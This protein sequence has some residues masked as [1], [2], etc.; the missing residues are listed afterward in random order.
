LP[1]LGQL[2]KAPSDEGAVKLP[3]FGNLTEGENNKK[4]GENESFSLPQ[5][6]IGCEE[7][8][9]ASPLIRGGQWRLRRQALSHSPVNGN[10]QE[11]PEPGRPKGVPSF[12]ALPVPRCQRALPARQTGIGNSLSYSGQEKLF[13]IVPEDIIPLLLDRFR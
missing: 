4:A 6:K 13:C 3:I 7:P 10:W 11:H 9:F 1:F 5:S 8:I 2:A 12:A